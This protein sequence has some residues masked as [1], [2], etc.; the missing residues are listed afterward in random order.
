MLGEIFGGK[1][2]K[3]FIK[4]IKSIATTHQV[5]YTNVQIRL[6][7]SGVEELPIKYERCIN[8][9]PQGEITYK[10]IMNI[11]MDLLGQEAMVTPVILQ[12][13]VKQSQELG[14]DA[15]KLSVFL[16]AKDEQVGVAIFDGGE[17][18]KIC[19]I[20]KLFE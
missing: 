11:N 7:F 18:K 17:N 10:R 15:E 13:M 8:W 3:D 4:G 1:I 14:I 5:E 6:T 12:S 2:A 16:F 9:Q 20:A 19:P